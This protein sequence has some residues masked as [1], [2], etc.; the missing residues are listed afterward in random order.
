M[1]WDGIG[2]AAGAR[3]VTMRPE[4]LAMLKAR[5]TRVMIGEKCWNDGPFSRSIEL[6]L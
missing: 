6:P 4:E 5:V 1:F 2:Y 3:T